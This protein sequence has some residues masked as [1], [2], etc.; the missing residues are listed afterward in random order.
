MVWID[1]REV[2]KP[3]FLMLQRD[4]PA[5]RCHLL[6]QSVIA[7]TLSNPSAAPTWV[8]SWLPSVVDLRGLGIV[9]PWATLFAMR[10]ELFPI[11]LASDERSTVWYVLVGMGPEGSAGSH[12]PEWWDIVA[13]QEARQSVEI[14]LRILRTQTD[15]AFFFWPLLSFLDR[16]LVRGPSLALPFL[17]AAHG[18][19]RGH[20]PGG[21]VASGR[22]AEDGSLGPVGGLALK[23]AAVVREG[24]TGFL[25][26]KPSKA[27]GD[28]LG[29]VERLEAQDL[30][31]A[32]FLWDTYEPGEGSGLIDNMRVLA[33]PLRLAANV[34]LLSDGAL[35]WKGFGT[36]YGHQI[37][38]ILGEEHLLGQFLDNLER[39][40]DSP[41]YPVN[42]IETLLAP[43]SEEKV[44]ILANHNPLAA[45]RIAQIQLTNGTRQG[46]V[47]EADLWSRLSS[48]LLAR[49]IATERGLELKAGHLNR[50]FVFQRHGR[51]DFRP[52]LPE[53]LTVVLEPLRELVC[54]KKR[55]HAGM[56]S[57]ALGR[58]YGTIA[59][60]YGFCGPLY[61]H[62]VERYVALAQEA[63]G[64]GEY[65]AY[66][67]DWRRQFCYRFYALLDAGETEPARQALDK[68]LGVSFD[69][70]TEDDYQRMNR[71][72][73]A[74]LARFLAEKGAEP[75]A[76]YLK[77]SI[78]KAFERLVEHPWQLW[79]NNVGRFVADKHVQRM[80]WS[81][82]V[83]LSLSLGVAA[84][85]MALLPLINLWQSGLW[86]DQR[87]K[88]KTG[89]VLKALQN[90]ALCLEHFHAYLKGDMWEE[91]LASVLSFKD[92]LFPFTYR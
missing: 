65:R 21:I 13:D 89:H 40:M 78:C 17:L 87:L 14:V 53:E 64:G 36:A 8:S 30:Q 55:Y 46:R 35:R 37:E 29:R 58:L 75:P 43:F 26:P 22:V 20:T 54:L 61:L 41:D 16:L 72:Q 28:V 44:D 27:G 73:H 7:A 5:S 11:V 66:E 67:E 82:S 62:E 12:F 15:R 60:N 25:Y 68:Y 39:A 45:F 23:A 74:A 33:N 88:E 42:R 51:Y 90:P 38:A 2:F 56:V 48:N 31:E 52:G 24:Y 92:R 4:F 6:P 71:Y 47:G 77:W 10:W 86:T 34:L 91:T 3:A 9:L 70:G 18:L 19:L 79:L 63:F 76:S 83:D 69:Q 80:V 50:K 57:A 85:P 81:R 59:Q 49:I 32:F 1:N 84:R